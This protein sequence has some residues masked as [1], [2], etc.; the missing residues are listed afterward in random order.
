MFSKVLQFFRE[1]EAKAPKLSAPSEPSA[2][3][4]SNTNFVFFIP[5]EYFLV[6]MTVAVQQENERK[7]PECAGCV[8]LSSCCKHDS[9]MQSSPARNNF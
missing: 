1:T 7:T 8:P 5:T 6:L 4:C 3:D 9:W 2:N